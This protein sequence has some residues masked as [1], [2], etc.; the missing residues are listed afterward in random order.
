[1]NSEV[2]ICWHGLRG[3]RWA[4][5]V[6]GNFMV[7]CAG[8]FSQILCLSVKMFLL[9][10]LS[11]P[12]MAMPGLKPMENSIPQVRIGAFVLMKMKETAGEKA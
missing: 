9:K 2:L 6:Y 12:L 7:D 5:T 10:L 3:G 11:V 1:M 4:L 8:M